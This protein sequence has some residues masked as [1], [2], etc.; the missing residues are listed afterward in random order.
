M[1][2][3]GE[4][5]QICDPISGVSKSGNAYAKQ[6]FVVEAKEEGLQFP[7]TVYVEAFGTD[8]MAILQTKKIGQV[9]SF[10]FTINAREFNG[11]YYTD[12]SLTRFLDEQMPSQPAP[13]PMPAQKPQ[14]QQVDD[15]LPF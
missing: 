4:I 11:R 1:K 5:K 13:S 9:V 3:T 14:P 8:K 15:G 7:M 2:L 12:I 10:F 6:G